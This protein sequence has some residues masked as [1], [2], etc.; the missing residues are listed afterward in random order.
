[1]CGGGGGGR[2]GQNELF[3]EFCSFADIFHAWRT[4]YLG[5]DG[6]MWLSNWGLRDS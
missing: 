6:E 4:K 5:R 3:V 2:G 1:M